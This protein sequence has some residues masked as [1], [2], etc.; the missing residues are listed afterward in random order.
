MMSMSC[1]LILYNEKMYTFYISALYDE[2][3]VL[4]EKY[5]Q[6]LYQ[7]DKFSVNSWYQI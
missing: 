5:T 1:H 4:L 2:T 6:N 7:T 3:V